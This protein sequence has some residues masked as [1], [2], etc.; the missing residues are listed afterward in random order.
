MKRILL[1]SLVTCVL[2]SCDGGNEP[3]LSR[4]LGTTVEFKDQQLKKV[5]FDD[6][7]CTAGTRKIL[8]PVGYVDKIDL[9]MSG[10]GSELWNIVSSSHI[11]ELGSFSIQ[12]REIEDEKLREVTLEFSG[13]EISDTTALVGEIY[14]GNLSLGDEFVASCVLTDLS[15]PW[16][17][18]YGYAFDPFRVSFYYSNKEVTVSGKRGSDKYAIRLN[19]GWNM[20]YVYC[21]PETETFEYTSYPK[22]DYTL[23]WVWCDDLGWG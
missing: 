12:L 18:M 10:N 2:C 21:Y 15:E 7:T 13:L 22:K 3:K 16:K 8:T 19:M 23:T 11:D 17:Y 6:D 14:D 1:I 5:V 20:V 4:P 9:G